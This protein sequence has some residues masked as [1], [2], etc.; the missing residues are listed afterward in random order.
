ME[1]VSAFSSDFGAD[2]DRVS[3]DFSA[4]STLELGGRARAWNRS[5]QGSNFRAMVLAKY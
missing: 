1:L 5:L 3:D 4:G 2:R